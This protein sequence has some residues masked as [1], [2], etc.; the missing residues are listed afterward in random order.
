MV[1]LQ[2]LEQYFVKKKDTICRWQNICRLKIKN[3]PITNEKFAVGQRRTCRLQ[4]FCLPSANEMFADG[5]CL[6]G[7]RQISLPINGKFKISNRQIFYLT[8]GNSF[9]FPAGNFS[10]RSK[11][12]TLSMQV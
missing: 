10:R 11:L 3:L 8:S 6:T 7:R 2:D 5:E 1:T 12:A 4:I 9:S